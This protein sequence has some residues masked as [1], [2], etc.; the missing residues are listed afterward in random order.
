MD[1]IVRPVL[2]FVA[3]AVWVMPFFLFR[4]RNRPKAVQTRPAARVGIV[5][6][7][8]AFTMVFTHR[9]ASWNEPLN[10]WRALL[11]LV[12]A[13]PGILLSWRSIRFLGRQWRV[14]TGLN[15]DHQL[16]RT[17]PYALIRHPIYASMLCMLLAGIAWCGTLPLWPLSL[18]LF[19]AG[20]EI[21]IR[22]ED[23]LLR[24]RFGA[25]FTRWAES[26]PAYLPFVR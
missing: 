3:W 2:F 24:E 4:P 1:P 15:A 6:Q 22:V 5:L 14:D 25:E 7:V 11:G 9:P 26:T 13:A 17:G 19:F 8:I 23:S 18:P 12:F 10:P 16:I 21:R 20:I